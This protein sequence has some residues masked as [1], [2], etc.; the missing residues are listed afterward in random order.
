MLS[1][2]GTMSKLR[3][4]TTDQR[5]HLL[6]LPDCD[7]LIGRRWLRHAVLALCA[8]LSGVLD[9]ATPSMALRNNPV[10]NTRARQ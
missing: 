5:I 10:W 3:A 7:R 8:S 2:Y 9:L 1:M 4:Q 6:N